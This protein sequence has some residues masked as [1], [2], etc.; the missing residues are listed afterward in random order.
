MSIKATKKS[1]NQTFLKV[2][3]VPYGDIQ[4]LTKDIAPIAYTCGMYGWNA[5]VYAFGSIAIVTGYRP[6]GKEVNRDLIDKFENR[7]KEI[8]HDRRYSEL[9]ELRNEFIKALN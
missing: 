7:A 1:I 8:V 2:F 6:F 3:C 4:Y 9:S 5:D